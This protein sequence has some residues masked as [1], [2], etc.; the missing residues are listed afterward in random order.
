MTDNNFDKIKKLIKIIGGKV[1]IVEDG[2]PTMVIID[3][4][5]YARVNDVKNDF[6]KRKEAEGNLERINLDINVWKKKQEE[7]RLKQIENNLNL[8][9]RKEFRAEKA[10]D[11]TDEEMV[12]EGL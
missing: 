9:C 6:S 2:K 1:I 10:A 3:V 12:V 8:D 11:K 5:E 4:D 7:R